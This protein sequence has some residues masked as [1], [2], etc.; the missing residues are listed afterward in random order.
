MCQ[1]SFYFRSHT[2]K[3]IE[4]FHDQVDPLLCQVN[5][6]QIFLLTYSIYLIE[7][8]KDILDSVIKYLSF[9][10]VMIGAPLSNG[11]HLRKEQ[12]YLD[13][14]LGGLVH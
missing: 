8:H 11:L 10:Q 3:F 14:I 9:S 2:F 12:A 5:L 13:S 7:P 4:N 1:K 6:Q